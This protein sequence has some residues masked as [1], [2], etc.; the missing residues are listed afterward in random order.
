MNPY[1]LLI[2]PPG[3]G[4][5]TQ[6]KRIAEKYDITHITTGDALR[7]HKDMETE[8]GTPREYMD[9]GELVPDPV[10]NEIVKVEIEEADGFVLDGYPR[11]LSQAEY[12]ESLIDLDVVVHLTIDDETVIERQT[13]RRVCSECGETYHVEFNPPE[14]EGVC[15]T[16]GGELI[17]RSDSDEE[18]VRER[19]RVYKEETKPV[20][21]FYRNRTDVVTI[22]G[23][24]NIEAVWEDIQEAIETNV[25]EK[26]D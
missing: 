6:S 25:E 12:L 21:D 24:Q 26:C 2:G 14:T 15:D 22:N 18:T 23:E 7:A 9:Q 16:C 10:V 3:A 1:I 5:G 20:I 8:Y 4:K 13:G 17:Q 19:L 11:N